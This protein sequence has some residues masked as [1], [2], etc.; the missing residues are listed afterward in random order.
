MTDVRT[1][2]AQVGIGR[3]VLVCDAALEQPREKLVSPKTQQGAHDLTAASRNPTQ[4]PEPCSSLDSQQDCFR[5]VIGLVPRHDAS[6]PESLS[7]RDQELVPGRPKRRVLEGQRALGPSD[8]TR[9]PDRLASS[10]AAI[11]DPARPRTKTMVEMR[12]ADPDPVRCSES[13]QKMQQG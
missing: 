10:H 12:G 11:R 1:R 8:M 13:R 5:L 7:L 4:T 9:D 2:P 3:I 6:R